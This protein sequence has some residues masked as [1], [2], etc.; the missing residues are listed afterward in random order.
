M[1]FYKY[2]GTGNDFIMVDDRPATFALTQAQI[3]N[4]CHRRFG[5][6]ADGLILLQNAPGYDFRM[7]YYNADGSQ[8]TMCGNGGRCAVRFAHD[9]SVIAD[10]TTFIAVDGPHTA[11]VCDENVYL[12]MKN[13]DAVE[14]HPDHD[15]A[16]TG[17][18][19]YIT[20]TQNIEN[21]DVYTKGQAIRYAPE[22]Q[23]KGGTNVN[24]VQ[25]QGENT[26]G[27]RTYERGVEDETYSCG[28]GVTAAAL[29]AS[30]KHHMQSP[31]HINTLGGKLEVSFQANADGSFTD[32]YLMGPATKVYQGRL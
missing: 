15:Y 13:V 1:Q 26:I 11:S 20:Y 9:L 31:I 3:E 7:V 22:W 25:I 28:T 32:V 24:F 16:N 10:S 19:H 18:P 21:E 12:Q 5:I 8:G 29:S 4:L 23:A 17:S 27:V 2:Q 6:G 14:Q 30:A